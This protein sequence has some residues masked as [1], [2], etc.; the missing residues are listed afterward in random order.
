MFWGC[1]DYFLNTVILQNFDMS[2]FGSPINYQVLVPWSGSGAERK[3]LWRNSKISHHFG[4]P[5][6]TLKDSGFVFQGV[7][8]SQLIQSW[9]SSRKWS[10]RLQTCYTSLKNSNSVHRRTKTQKF[11]CSN[12]HKILRNSLQAY[13]CMYLDQGT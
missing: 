8:R 7:G 13:L 6:E 12:L 2:P 1:S 9:N 5:Q 11:Y 10:S 4:G 3:I